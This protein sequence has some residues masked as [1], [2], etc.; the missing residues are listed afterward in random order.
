MID[1]AS[2]A[3]LAPA[4]TIKHHGFST[5]STGQAMQSEHGRL[6]AQA[7]LIFS[8][9]ADF[10]APEIENIWY[11]HAKNNLTLK[12]RFLPANSMLGR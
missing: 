12:L 8:K 4:S 3:I 1:V 7:G 6:V 10:S 9:L 11:K 2:C 5:A